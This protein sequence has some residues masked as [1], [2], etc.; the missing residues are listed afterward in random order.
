MKKLF[1]GAV[2]LA[3][4]PVI[5]LYALYPES[6]LLQKVMLGNEFFRWIMI[7]ILLIAAF[8]ISDKMIDRVIK[9]KKDI[10]CYK[11]LEH[12]PRWEEFI[13]LI[14]IACWFVLVIFIN[15]WSFSIAL[16]LGIFLTKAFNYNKKNAIDKLKNIK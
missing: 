3:L 16:L 4:M 15:D 6:A 7:P 2:S 5:P 9:K 8:G 13:E 12:N 10:D 14:D 11:K 1:S